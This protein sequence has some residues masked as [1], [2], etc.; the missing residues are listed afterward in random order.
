MTNPKP[1]LYDLGIAIGAITLWLTPTDVTRALGY[2]VSLL[3]SGRAYY[4]GICLLSKEKKSDEKE[5][6]AYEA[7]VDFYDQLLGTNIEAALEVKSLEVENRMLERM[8]P[9]IAQK[10]QLERQLQSIHPPHPEMSDEER[11]QAAKAAIDEAFVVE[12]KENNSEISEQDIRQKFP[13]QLDSVSW[14]AILK[15]L[16]AGATRDEIVKDVL[17]C[18]ESS[19]V[20]KAYFD[21]LKRRFLDD[22]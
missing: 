11:K 13:E 16:Q 15:A 12:S 7:E 18:P 21:L 1:I 4:T 5:G 14:K 9:L 6:I 2:T 3:F 10:V 8:I 17:G 22:Q 19:G 20:G